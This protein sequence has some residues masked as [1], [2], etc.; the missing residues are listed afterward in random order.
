[1]NQIAQGPA[2]RRSQLAYW[3]FQATG[4]GLYTLSRF[5]G[6]LTVMHL[7]WLNF[8]CQLLLVDALGFGFSHVL[9]GYVRRRKWRTLPIHKLALRIIGAAFI[10]GTPLGVLTEFTDVS[11]LQDPNE[12][13]EGM[14]S[15]LRLQLALPVAIALEITNWSTVFLVWQ[16][17]YFGA[18]ALREY[19][20]AQLRQSETARALHLA[21]LRLL[22]S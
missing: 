9:R 22:K 11:L 13:L 18:I 14:S 19:R 7:P 15:P 1:M 2:P 6:G 8:G 12:F 16:I 21:E 20:G 10:C 17:L 3:S 5:I 4:W